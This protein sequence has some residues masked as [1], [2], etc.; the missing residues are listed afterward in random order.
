MKAHAEKLAYEIAEALKEI[1]T[2]KDELKTFLYAA[3]LSSVTVM[4]LEKGLDAVDY[5]YSKLIPDSLEIANSIIPRIM[6][7]FS[8]RSDGEIDLDTFTNN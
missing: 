7:E 1:G 6:H 8:E 3:I 2:S 5:C 4:P